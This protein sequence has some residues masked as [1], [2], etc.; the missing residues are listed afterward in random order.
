[1]Q[2][3]CPSCYARMPLDVAI[4]DQETRRAVQVALELPGELGPLVLKYLS[5]FTP[6]KK[7]LA[8]SKAARLLSDLNTA[9]QDKKVR[10]QGRDWQISVDTWHAAITALLERRDQ[11]KLTLPL[12]DHSYLFAIATEMANKQEATE[13]RAA[14]KKIATGSRQPRKGPAQ[15]G[16]EL[17]TDPDYR[18]KVNESLGLD[19]D[20]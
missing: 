6:P 16:D 12:K 7:S 15:I 20:A 19:P 14:E 2:I 9:V 8:W 1:M 11:G 4:N 18:A 13:E 3:T 17:M 10:R 5:C